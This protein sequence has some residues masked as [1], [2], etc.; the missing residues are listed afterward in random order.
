MLAVVRINANHSQVSTEVF[1]T[2]WDSNL[3]S[4]M[5]SCKNDSNLW[6][7]Q[8][9]PMCHS[10]NRGAASLVLK[11]KKS[12]F[13]AHFYLFLLTFCISTFPKQKPRKVIFNKAKP[14]RG[15]E[16]TLFRSEIKRLLVSQHWKHTDS[17]LFP[18]TLRSKH[19]YS[20]LEVLIC[21]KKEKFRETS[22]T[23]TR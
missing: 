14:F 5:A 19:R 6:Q 1:H 11:V 10:A 18:F 17:Q 7:G 23:H 21:N 3:L 13:E 2:C 9:K 8:A 16:K 22:I 12:S 4:E 15:N 20:A